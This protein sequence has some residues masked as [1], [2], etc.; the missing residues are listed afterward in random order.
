MIQNDSVLDEGMNALLE[1]SS[2]QIRVNRLD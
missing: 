2:G 1:S